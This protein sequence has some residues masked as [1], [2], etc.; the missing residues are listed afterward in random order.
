MLQQYIFV[1]IYITSHVSVQHHFAN[2]NSLHSQ[3]NDVSLQHGAS[4]FSGCI[5]R[6]H[7]FHRYP[8][9]YLAKKHH[10]G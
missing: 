5:Q 8:I 9:W 7:K 2:H 6:S 3:R 1:A 10:L 4:V